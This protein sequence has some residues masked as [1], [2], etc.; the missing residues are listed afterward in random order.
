[1]LSTGPVAYGPVYFVRN[2]AWRTGKDGVGRTT[3]GGE[4]SV[5]ATFFKY[6]GSSS[7]AAR[8]YVL[9]NTLWT[10]S[11]FAG[12]ADKQ[13]GVDGAGQYAGGGGSPE[14]LYLRNNVVRATRYAFQ[15]AAGWGEEANSFSTTDATRGLDAYGRWTTDVAGYRATPRSGRRT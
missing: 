4:P 15:A 10:D 7:P 6:S 2:Q 11:T 8:V 5:A 14:R 1:M 12:P 13:Q 3:G 9:H